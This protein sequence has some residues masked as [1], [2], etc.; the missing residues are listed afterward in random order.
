MLI[1]SDCIFPIIRKEI[2]SRKE[3]EIEFLDHILL[4]EIVLGKD[5][6]IFVLQEIALLC[7]FEMALV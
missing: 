6:L 3:E 2:C 7:W 5:T 1:H 4:T